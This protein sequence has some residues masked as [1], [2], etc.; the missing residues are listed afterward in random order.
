MWA[1]V[2]A[3]SSFVE[4]SARGSGELPE[5]Q[6]GGGR[7]RRERAAGVPAPATPALETTFEVE[8][9]G[10]LLLT[11]S[12]TYEGA[13]MAAIFLVAGPVAFAV[14]ALRMDAPEPEA[15]SEAIARLIDQKRNAGELGSQPAD[16][17]LT[18]HLVASLE[19]A[20]RIAAELPINETP[21]QALNELINLAILGE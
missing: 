2:T 4:L 18:A 5:Q 8:L 19:E 16:P 10:D 6:G 13:G 15:E 21:T 3:L 17:V 7:G 9:S 14:T 11:T 12:A 20:E 1:A